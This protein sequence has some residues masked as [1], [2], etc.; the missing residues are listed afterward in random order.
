MY[1]RFGN[2][3]YDPFCVSVKQFDL[4]MNWL[5]ENKLAVSFADMEKFLAGEKTLSA[6]SVLITVDDGFSSVYSE[7]LPVL[8]RWGI[9]AVAY[10]S[11]GLVGKEGHTERY[12]TWDE[13]GK[14]VESGVVIGSHAW[15]HRSLGQMTAEEV[16]DEAC[17]SKETLQER[18]G[19]GVTTFA[20]P[21]GTRAA[22][23]ELTGTILRECGYQTAFTTQH[24]AVL[25]GSEAIE[26]PR[27]KVEG[28]DPLWMFRQLCQGGIDG[29]RYADRFLWRLQKSPAR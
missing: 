13:L 2:T 6:D 23:S 5:A 28:G 10:V 1:H 27:I 14:L 19:I 21:Y 29:W 15:S 20:Y 25:P 3:P 7:M 17:R 8:R 9:P 4:Q 11:P 12:M 24:G 18:L 22:Y 26:L 16:R